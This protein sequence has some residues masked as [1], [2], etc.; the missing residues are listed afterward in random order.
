[1]AIATMS[2]FDLGPTPP[3]PQGPAPADVM[4]VGAWTTNAD[5]IADVARLGYLDGRVLDPTYGLGGFWRRWQPAELIAS[6]LDPAK[7]PI[8]HSVDFTRLPWPAATFEAVAF[9]PPYK[10]NGT[11]DA[12]VDAR[13]GVHVPTTWQDRMALIRD[14]IAE[15]VR[16]LRPGG[17]LLIKCQ[18]QVCSGRVRWQTREFADHAEAH[19]CE[20]IDRFDLLAHR[21]QPPGRRQ[22]H[23]RRNASTLLVMRRLGT[24]GV[25]T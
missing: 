10:L 13:Y 2:L 1:M 17:H 12:A 21:P 18:D 25:T 8:G 3:T 11:P 22:V 15:A 19:G 6:D 9:D 24:E 4:A 5:L 14:G 7:S 20:L 16:V 23:A